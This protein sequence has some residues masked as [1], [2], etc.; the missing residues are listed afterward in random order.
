MAE[1]SFPHP[2][3][4][5]NP[6]LFISNY[7]GIR[8]QWTSSQGGIRL[9]FMPDGIIEFVIE[10]FYREMPFPCFKNQGSTLY[11]LMMMKLWEINRT[12]RD[13]NET[14]TYYE[15]M[16]VSRGKSGR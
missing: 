8:E 3:P 2:P 5:P 15:E 9:R 10:S 6:N 12:D 13:T 4:H 16:E 11:R 7:N 1:R 14:A